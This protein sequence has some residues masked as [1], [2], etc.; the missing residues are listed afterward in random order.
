MAPA[1]IFCPETGLKP[2]KD[3][4]GERM[5]SMFDARSTRHGLALA[6]TVG[7]VV[8]MLPGT[9]IGATGPDGEERVVPKI[10][11]LDG[12]RG[13]AVGPPRR[14]VY[15][16]A[17]GSV[18][19][20]VLRGDDAG[21]T[22]LGTVTPGFAP[23]VSQRDFKSAYILTGGGED[24]GSATLFMWSK[25]TGD[26]TPVADIAAY[27]KTD[28]DPDNQEGNP[29][30]SNPFGVASLEDGSALVSDAAGNDL[31]HVWPNG[32]IAIR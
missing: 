6:A 24:E 25:S 31:L 16:Q 14:I 5:R 22:V 27:Q 15:S 17:D 4:K 2:A 23:A 11:G 21:T 20:T 13:I 18:S 1:G 30:E 19:Q 29:K 9:A 3:L 12:P 8:A 7:V 26:I 32:D 10:T 28:P